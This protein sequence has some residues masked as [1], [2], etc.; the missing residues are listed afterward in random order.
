MDWPRTKIDVTIKLTLT[1]K[2]VD[3][4]TMARPLEKDF[5][6]SRAGRLTQLG[7]ALCLN[8]VNTTSGRGTERLL[9]HLFRFEHLLAWAR[10]AGAIDEATAKA[11][12]ADP[13]AARVGQ[14]VLER[15]LSLRDALHAIFTAASKGGPAP[16]AALAEFNTCLAEAMA[17]AAIEST[18]Q[19]FA[20]RWTAGAMP[21]ESLLWPI[22][23]SAAELL[24]EGD[25]ARIKVCPG[26][27]CGWT[28]LDKTRNGRRRWC[29]MEI[30]G[31]RAKMRRYHQRQREIAAADNSF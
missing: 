18:P 9:E 14:Q 2:A 20:W 25:L 21:P 17:A 26:C 4:K 27:F 11:L 30:C 10:H 3:L 22:V 28:F 13:P 29:E 16:V 19:G 7:G 12:E 6:P 24:T 5:P 15:A 31:S 1:G 23:R 8:F